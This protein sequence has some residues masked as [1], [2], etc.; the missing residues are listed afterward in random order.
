M[1]VSG[2]RYEPA[3]DGCLRRLNLRVEKLGWSATVSRPRWNAQVAE[4][5]DALA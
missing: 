5:A 4:L 2:S 3:E 1:C